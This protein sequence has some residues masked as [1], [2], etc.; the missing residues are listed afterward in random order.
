MMSC[1][2]DE[3]ILEL[4]GSFQGVLAERIRRQPCNWQIA[5]STLV[6]VTLLLPS[7]RSLI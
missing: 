7:A 1:E 5:G 4:K 6:S 2:V 3:A